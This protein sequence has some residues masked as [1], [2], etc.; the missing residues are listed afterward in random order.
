MLGDLFLGEVPVANRTLV[1]EAATNM[2]E[3]MLPAY[4]LCNVVEDTVPGFQARLR[5]R[6]TL[7]LCSRHENSRFSKETV[8]VAT[9]KYWHFVYIELNVL[10]GSSS[11]PL[12]QARSGSVGQPGIISLF[13]VGRAFHAPSPPLLSPA[14]VRAIFPA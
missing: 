10:L 8:A 5:L 11:V 1:K 7:L 13:R 12:K 4:R 2:R 3:T 6:T 14:S 9:L